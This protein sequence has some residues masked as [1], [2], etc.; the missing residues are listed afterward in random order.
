MSTCAHPA[1]LFWHL[2]GSAYDAIWDSP[3]TARLNDELLFAVTRCVHVL[4]GSRVVDLGC[5]T[6]LSAR[7]FT[8]AG[9]HVFGIDSEPVVLE[10]AQSKGWLAESFLGDATATSLPDSC[11]DIAVLSNLLQVC[12][13]PVA[14]LDEAARLVSDGTLVVVWPR[15]DLTLSGLLHEDRRAGRSALSALLAYIGRMGFGLMGALVGARSW[16]SPALDEMLDRW[17]GTRGWKV[18][19]RGSLGRISSYRILCSR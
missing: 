18:A 3:L 14:T 19:N 5:G 7:S 16:S 11:A 13:N 15:G 10:R 9:C 1:S 12:A 2:Y 17:A 6:G 4:R 8:R